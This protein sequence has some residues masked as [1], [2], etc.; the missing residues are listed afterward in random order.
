[1]R[2]ECKQVIGENL[3]QVVRGC[4]DLSGYSILNRPVEDMDEA[5]VGE[6][7]RANTNWTEIL[8]QGASQVRAY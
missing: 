3:V 2:P 1:M 5:A 7:E 8:Y 4:A 6:R